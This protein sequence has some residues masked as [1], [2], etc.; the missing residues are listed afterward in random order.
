MVDPRDL[1][2][3]GRSRVNALI[4][5]KMTEG[6]TGSGEIPPR[7]VRGIRVT[8]TRT[9]PHIPEEGRDREKLSRPSLLTGSRESCGR[10]GFTLCSLETDRVFKEIDYITFPE[11]YFEQNFL[12]TVHSLWLHY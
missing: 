8:R 2:L 12:Q 4:S 5:S 10:I 9:E 11:I 1:S 7:M 3:G 6:V